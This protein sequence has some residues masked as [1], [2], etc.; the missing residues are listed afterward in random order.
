VPLDIPKDPKPRKVKVPPM[1]QNDALSPEDTIEYGITMEVSAG[2]GQKA[3]IKFGTTSS[4]RDGE[5]T[6]EARQRV[7]TWVD[8]QLDRRLDELS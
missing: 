7:P 8:E 2:P 6:E 4:V 5:T 1:V 3:W